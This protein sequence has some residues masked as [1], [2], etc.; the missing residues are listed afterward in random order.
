MDIKISV[1]IPMYNSANYL[2]KCVSSLLEQTM[3]EW[4]VILVNDCSPD[5]SLELANGYAAAHPEKV[6]VIDHKQNLRAGAARNNGL[7]QARGKYVWFVDADDWL[8]PDALEKAYTVAE[9]N[10]SD[11][12]SVDFYEVISETEKPVSLQVAVD[13]SFAGKMDNEKRQRYIADCSGGFSKLLRRDFLIRN[14]LYYPEGIRYEDN[15]IVTLMGAV[16]DRVDTIHEGLYYYRINNPNSQ[17]SVA[18][19][20][21]VLKDRLEAM[22][23]FYNKAMTLGLMQDLHDGIEYFFVYIYYASNVTGFV[24][25]KTFFSK[26]F[27]SGMKAVSHRRFPHF[28]RNSYIRDRFTRM[29]RLSMNAAELGYMPLKLLQRVYSAYKKYASRHRKG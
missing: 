23:Y 22:D 14:E 15:G 4:E 7:K 19:K 2:D 26:A 11:I 29:C 16:A 27:F 21:T 17:T 12:V 10:G 1:I 18:L 28:R 3:Q 5:N 13:D 9:E 8:A 24:Q 20:E 25:G 6:V